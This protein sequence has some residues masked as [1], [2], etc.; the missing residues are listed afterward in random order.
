[1]AQTYRS[2]LS[3]RL[4]TVCGELSYAELGRL[5]GFN[6]ETARRYVLGLAEPSPLFLAVLCEGLGHSPEWLLLGRGR[7]TAGRPARRG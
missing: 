3:A 2:E 6:Y 1:M 4:L 5:T 7:A